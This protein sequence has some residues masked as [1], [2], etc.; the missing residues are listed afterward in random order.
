[1][2]NRCKTGLNA[3]RVDEVNTNPTIKQVES[4]F[5]KSSVYL[6]VCLAPSCCGDGSCVFPA[7]RGVR[8]GVKR[9]GVEG[10]VFAGLRCGGSE[11]HGP[12]DGTLEDTAHRSCINSHRKY[13]L[14]LT[15]DLQC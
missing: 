8:V 11:G 9:G 12:P 7:C 5:F 13:S 6:S 2:F 3:S 14:Y 4:V 1:M 10:E 15:L